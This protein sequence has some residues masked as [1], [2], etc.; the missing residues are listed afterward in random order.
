MPL[1]TCTPN[2][3]AH[4]SV[5]TFTVPVMH[6]LK[7]ARLFLLIML[8]LFTRQRLQAQGAGPCQISLLF[9]NFN[10]AVYLPSSNMYYSGA[11]GGYTWECWFRLTQS[12]NAT[13][14]RPLINAVDGVV[15][16]DMYLGFGWNGGFFNEPGTNLVFKVDGPSSTV[17]SGPNCAYAPPGGFLANVWYHA[18]GVMNYNTQL[19]T[20]YVNGVPV[21]TKTITTP[22]ITRVIPTEL[23][24]NWNNTPMPLYGNMDEVRIWTR[25]LSATEILTNYNQCLAG[26]EANLFVYYNCNQPGG[27]WVDDA[28]PNNN[29]GT[30]ATNANF[31]VSNAPVTGTACSIQSSTVNLIA[32]DTII[33]PGQSVTLTAIGIPGWS[34]TWTPNTW[35][36][37][38]N[39]GVVNPSSTTTY[40]VWGSSGWCLPYL[41]T[42]TIYVDPAVV[43]A[44]LDPVICVGETTTLTATGAATYTWS[45]G[46]N[47][48][49]IIVSPP[50]TTGYTVTGT[51]INNCVSQ[52]TMMVTVSPPATVTAASSSSTICSGGTATLTASGAL[53]YTWNTGANASAIVVSPLSTT[54]FSVYGGPCGTGTPALVTVSV[55]PSPII[56]AMASSSAVCVGSTNTLIATGAQSY[57]WSNS[58]TSNS[59]IVSPPFT[60]SYTVAGTANS[61]TSQAVVIASVVAGPALAVSGASICIGGSAT[62]T[63]SGGSSYLWNGPAGYTATTANAVI[64][65]VT[66]ASAGIYT[67]TA[68]NGGLCSAT[69]TVELIGFPYILPVASISA[70]PRACL[71]APVELK[72]SGGVSYAWTGP[73]NFFSNQ[74]STGFIAISQAMSGIYT[75]NITNSNNCAGSGTVLINIYPVPSAT[76]VANNNRQCVPLCSSFS[77]SVAPGNA[78]FISTSYN[79][80]GLFSSDTAFSYCFQQ[81]GTQAVRVLFTDTNGC[82]NT[83][84]VMITAYPKPEA[85][86]EFAPRIPLEGVEPVYFTNT[87]TGDNLVRYDWFFTDKNGGTSHK[88]NASYVY[89]NA[90]AYP[91]VLVVSNN[92]GCADTVIKV[93]KV[94]NDFAIYVP[95]AFSPNGDGLNDVFQP[96][97]V[98]ITGY[99]LEVFDRWGEK[100]FESSDFFAGWDGMYKGKACKQDSYQWKI[101]VTDA[102]G[103]NKQLQGHV[104]LIN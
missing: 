19:A 86:F 26:T 54:T 61:C 3:Y 38:S 80:P 68:T 70:T 60:I 2:S 51:S 104:T 88:P 17:P 103:K 82:A 28:T 16:E 20:L 78:P 7:R 40:S 46:A 92:W 102:S 14:F 35:S 63:S 99:R 10:P 89:E 101:A 56:N 4:K 71:N 66:A 1:F 77:L 44:P 6:V 100:L 79:I 95:N 94:E 22:P 83:S 75:L 48:S 73:N 58:A 45:T 87:S 98:G 69:T 36:I 59:I 43:A 47:T 33:C 37:P 15:F 29:N 52:A 67:V 41:D 55:T 74:P 18:A 39:T 24:F 12:L 96:K 57:T 85:D 30:F 65:V 90:G 81:A 50:V 49:S 32:T 93:V 34:Y 5:Y 91:V 64:P 76:L 23:S 97:G 84:T 13:D 11:N 62:L 72:G 25:P 27:N 53:S 9:D 42:I 8:F 21:D 31:Q